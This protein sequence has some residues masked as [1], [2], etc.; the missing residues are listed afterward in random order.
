MATKTIFTVGFELPTSDIFQ[1]KSFHSNAS[2]LDA[3]I[4]TQFSLQSVSNQKGC[5]LNIN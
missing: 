5:L 1:F 4:I 2:L 3:D